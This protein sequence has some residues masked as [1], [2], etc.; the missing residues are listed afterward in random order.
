MALNDYNFGGNAQT[1]N[2]ALGTAQN[3]GAGVLS[4]LAGTNKQYTDVLGAYSPTISNQAQQK[5]YQDVSG[6]TGIL[7]NL[8][9][10]NALTTYA[11]EQRANTANLI[12]QRGLTGQG[13]ANL[14]MQ[15]T[16]DGILNRLG[17]SVLNNNIANID[18]RNNAIRQAADLA[19]QNWDAYEWT[20]DYDKNELNNL[21]DM[22]INIL[23]ETD[24]PAVAAKLGQGILGII[25]KKGE[26]VYGDDWTNQERQMQ[27][28]MNDYNRITPETNYKEA[29][30]VRVQNGL[31]NMNIN[32]LKTLLED[33]ET[34]KIAEQFGLSLED[35][36][37]KVSF[38]NSPAG[39]LINEIADIKLTAGG[40]GQDKAAAKRLASAVDTI[41]DWINKNSDFIGSLGLSLD[42]DLKDINTW[43]TDK[44]N[45]N[46]NSI[47]ESQ[48]ARQKKINII[49]KAIN[50]ILN[51]MGISKSFSGGYWNSYLQ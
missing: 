21:F 23:A 49:N 31:N 43:N 50:K 7:N 24:D 47:R 22:Y 8:K 36:N 40:G 11:K 3:T 9:T 20:K 28:K 51:A 48:T 17:E 12:N 26:E 13:A 38:F 6:E 37:K 45:N 27:E 19:K 34:Q 15:A 42:K 4:G 29:D 10:S 2:N 25:S 41:Q 44:W 18:V 33:P 46:R 5:L 16:D 30:K 39:S 32:E 1:G 35:A 14:A